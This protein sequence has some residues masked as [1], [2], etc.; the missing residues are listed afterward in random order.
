MTTASEYA[1]FLVA[2]EEPREHGYA[3]DEGAGHPDAVDPEAPWG[4]KADGSP[5][6]KPG[7]PSGTPDKSP[8]SRTRRRISASAPPRRTS[9]TRPAKKPEHP[10]YVPGLLGIA[11]LFA[12]PLMVAGLKSPALALDAAAITV[13]A[14]SIAQAMQETAE[15]VPQFAAVLDKVL[16]VG[17]YGALLGAVLPFGV[18]LLANHGVLP[19]V[20]AKGMGAQSADELLAE[21]Q[22]ESTAA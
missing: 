1:P 22:G 20:V 11:Q 12:A 2:G 16:T 14:E 8:R 13:H 18:Q 10:D 15:Q 4:R 5:K 19:E 17:P 6:A 7:R 21:L 3:D 9:K